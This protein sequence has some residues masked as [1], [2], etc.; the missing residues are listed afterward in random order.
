MKLIPLSKTGKHKGKYFAM[1]DDEDFEYLNQ[2]NWYC[3]KGKYVERWKSRNCEFASMHR[4]IL[5][6]TV[7]KMQCDHIDHNGLNNQKSNLRVCTSSQNGMNKS[8]RGVSKY[9]G[10][11]FRKNNNKWR[12]IIGLNRKYKE[13]GMFKTEIEA[14]KAYDEA[15]KIYF[16]EFANLNFK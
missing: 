1:V 2:F 3:S 10:V 5:N 4:M 6:L 13:L 15:A 12:A 14:A 16:K 9:L 11:S 7:H 8:A